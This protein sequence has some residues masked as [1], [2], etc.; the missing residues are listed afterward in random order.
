MR[1]LFYRSM[2]ANFR[3]S[4]LYQIKI[5]KKRFKNIWFAIQRKCSYPG[6]GERKAKS[7]VTLDFIVQIWTSWNNTVTYGLFLVHVLW[8]KNRTHIFLCV[9]RQQNDILGSAS[10]RDVSLRLSFWKQSYWMYLTKPKDK[11]KTKSKQNN[12]NTQE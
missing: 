4:T 5:H 1:K 12:K 3:R 2:C 11:Q 7:E 6:Q 10:F 9:W 8:L